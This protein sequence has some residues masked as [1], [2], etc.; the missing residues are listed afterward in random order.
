MRTPLHTV[1]S[2][3][4]VQAAV[5]PA[6]AR[7][8]GT[9]FTSLDDVQVASPCTADWNTMA[10]DGRVRFCPQCRQNVYH[11]SAMTTEQATAL[12]RE[13]ERTPCVR[14]FRRRDGTVMTADCPVGIRQLAGHAWRWTATMLAATFAVV[15]GLLGWVIARPRA[16]MGALS[17][18]RCSSGSSSS[19]GQGVT[20]G[21]IG[22]PP[23][24]AG[25]GV[26]REK[27]AEGQQPDANNHND[28]GDDEAPPRP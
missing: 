20:M 15:L 14:F 19:A 5:P 25:D 3:D 18:P 23:R 21:D 4:N 26:D 27:L 13:K 24:K 8:R 2:L 22:R 9:T 10:G 6:S 17:G 16:T 12:L 11:I 1:T 28:D 7:Q